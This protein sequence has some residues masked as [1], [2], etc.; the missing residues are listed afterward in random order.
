M[1][2]TKQKLSIV[3]VMILAVVQ[4]SKAQEF[5]HDFG[6]YSAEEF[7]MKKYDKDPAAEAVVIYD[8]GLTYFVRTESGFDMVFER[9]TKLK[10][11][12][13]AG[14]KYSQFEVQYYIGDEKRENV[15]EIIGNTYNMENGAFRKTSL[16]PKNI[17]DE[18]NSEHWRA[19]KFAMPDVKDG[20]VIEVQYKIISPFFFNFRH[21]DF[22]KK[23]PV[24]FSEYTTKM[25]P[26]YE[27][28][29]ILHGSN[30]FDRFESYVDKGLPNQ[31]GPIT[32]QDMIYVFGMNDIPAFK[33][34]EFITC[35][36]DY[37]IS[38]DFQLSVIHRLNGTN[39][40]IM[41][42]WPKLIEEMLDEDSFG[43]YYKASLKCGKAVNDTMKM[44]SRSTN[45]K[46]TI[47]DRYV[48]AN[49]NWNGNESKFASKTVKEFLKE[50]TGNSAD[51][52]LYLAGL[53]NGVGVE[54]YPV[55]ISTR[56]NGKIKTDYPF[57][58]FFNYVIVMLK[59]DDKYLFMDATEP[60]LRFSE[61]PTRCFNDRGLIINKQKTEWAN[62][63]S[64]IP[65]LTERDIKLT[66]TP[67]NDSITGSF[68]IKATGYDALDLRRKYFKN[69]Q[70]FK[71]EF[72][73]ENL[74]ITDSIQTNNLDQ[75]DKPFDITFNGL[76]NT[77]RVEDKILVSPFCDM[78]I[79]ENPLKQV[80]RTYPIDMV[81]KNAHRYV[82]TITIPDDY[83]IVNK[84][85][86]LSINN[87][88]I[89][90]QYT[91]EEVDNTIKVYGFYNFKKDVYDSSEYT[92]VKGYFSKIVDK[93]NEKIVL[94]KK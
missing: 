91:F 42:T 72:S 90:L 79:S 35:P 93:F 32:Y 3:L 6:K 45:E 31:F 73:R 40:K 28:T 74:T 78:A 63:S 4:L 2:T 19:K 77:E 88:Q 37:M 9:R 17:F 64:V 80:F 70:N 84:P 11:F 62:F 16:N 55:L 56:G 43:K 1:E 54:A 85:A 53:L 60:L 68:K 46:A 5:T 22:Q 49:F 13:K 61:L 12:N 20:S 87:N 92:Y 26:F 59:I 86:N 41:T 15:E 39:E 69:T 30:K 29:Y 44:Q 50:K 7:Q 18:K 58:H 34:E 82:S 94:A 71:K 27:Y 75:I 65:S 8:I 23:I 24:I 48:K 51:M 25:I 36:E 57:Q 52:N 83:K 89:E 81:Y 38:L 33:D 76:I 47:L 10:I 14:L 66:F 21:W 67:K